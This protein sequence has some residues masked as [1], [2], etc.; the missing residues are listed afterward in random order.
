MDRLRQ[1]FLEEAYEHAGALEA[2]VLALEADLS[3]AT[4]LDDVF[5]AAHS[6]KGAAG[7]I[8]LVALTSLTHSLETLLDSWRSGELNPGREHVTALLHS[9]DGIRLL[10]STTLHPAHN[11]ELPESLRE[12]R[13]ELDRLALAQPHAQPVASSNDSVPARVYHIEFAPK[14]EA[15]QFGGDPLLVLR[16]LRGHCERFAVLADT[17]RLPTLAELNPES[18]Y[19]SWS[20]DVKL[21]PDA[22]RGAIDEAFSFAEA[23]SDIQI[24]AMDVRAE[25]P[26]A[27]QLARTVERAEVPAIQARDGS[28]LRVA[29]EK[30][31]KLVDLVGELVIAHSAVKE[32]SREPT[33]ERLARLQE[34]V[35]ETERHLRE[36]QERVMSIRMVPVATILS[37][38]PR[39]VRE[40][41]A[42]LDKEVSLLLEGGETELDKGLAERL[43]DPLLH[44]VRNALDHGIETSAERQRTGKSPVGRLQI[45]ARPMGGSVVIEVRDDGRGLDREKIVRKAREKG[46]LTEHETCSDEQAFNLITQPGFSTAEAVTNL[47]GRGVGLDVVRKNIE[48]LGGELAIR[49][50]PGKG[51]CFTLRLPLTLT[52]MDG[53]LL[54]AGSTV[55]V[56]PLVDVAF[57]VRLRPNQQRPLA[58]V[59]TVIDLPGE[60]LSLL[61][62]TQI[63]GQNSD[64]AGS[65]LAVVLQTG[66]HRFAIRVDALLGQS[67]VVVKS[68]ETHF[69]RV[70]GILGATILGDG[71]VALILDAAGLAQS[72]GLE[73]A[74]NSGRA[75]ARMETTNKWN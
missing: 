48:E 34:A 22:E 6:L 4:L 14:V 44:L 10:L 15:L 60:S 57:S 28:T 7:S 68:L 54:R 49:S 39:L 31:D 47:S 2:G 12:L 20:L 61:E 51:A 75:R 67:Q 26:A 13:D 63:L 55:C 45:S 37:R 8:G 29:T 46:L 66:A 59:G 32:L 69:R 70:P 21:L 23:C 3:N 72:F 17:S 36:L 73:R 74:D 64:N 24:D 30:V 9:C 65:E 5:R 35:A 50:E 42:S 40:V 38:L 53:L 71:Q 18:S 62:L 25:T 11:G 19:L 41:S 43:G 56:V 16:E 52:I 33:P 58:D 1:L 27:E